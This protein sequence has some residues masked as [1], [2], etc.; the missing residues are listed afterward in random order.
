LLQQVNLLSAPAISPPSSANHI[1]TSSALNSISKIESGISTSIFS[2]SI[3]SK[4]DIW[5]LD[6][7]AN[8]HIVL[9]KQQTSF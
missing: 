5:L 2:C 8:E 3:S 6:S 9:D 4:F 7:G 1:H